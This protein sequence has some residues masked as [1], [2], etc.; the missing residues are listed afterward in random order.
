MHNLQPFIIFIL[1][2]KNIYTR[3]YITYAFIYWLELTEKKRYWNVHVYQIHTFLCWPH[4]ACEKRTYVHLYTYTYENRLE[5]IKQDLRF[6]NALL[7]LRWCSLNSQKNCSSWWFRSPAGSP[8][9]HGCRLFP[10]PRWE[11]L[12][13]APNYSLS[14]PPETCCSLPG[15]TKHIKDA[16]K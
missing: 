6:V 10:E 4:M 16:K 3:W 15:E 7:C 9:A 1:C 14:G 5:I 8:H 11:R 13:S 2:I 12:W